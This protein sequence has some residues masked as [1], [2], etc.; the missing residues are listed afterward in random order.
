MLAD[1]QPDEELKHVKRNAQDKSRRNSKS[2]VDDDDAEDDEVIVT[3]PRRAVTMSSTTAAEAMAARNAA[4]ATT[5]LRYSSR[6]QANTA[7]DST[8]PKQIPS[9]LAPVPT[10][11]SGPSPA[12][13]LQALQPPTFIQGVR[14]SRPLPT[15]R[16]PSRSFSFSSRSSTKR[17]RERSP[18]SAESECSE[19]S[20]T[21]ES[22]DAFAANYSAPAPPQTRANK[23]SRHERVPDIAVQDTAHRAADNGRTATALRVLPFQLTASRQITPQN[24]V[25][26]SA[27]FKSHI[28]SLPVRLTEAALVKSGLRRLRRNRPERF[29][30]IQRSRQD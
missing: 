20:S 30:D 22:D 29:T 1:L 27:S 10:R 26:V 13:V 19:S 5:N 14:I 8:P 18:E 2:N 3:R 7:P 12:S 4:N 17:V 15:K 28:H 9:V 25:D 16:P 21:T 6:F 24:P 23:R 11:T